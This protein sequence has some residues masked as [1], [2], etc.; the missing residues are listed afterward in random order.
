VELGHVAKKVTAGE[1]KRG[2]EALGQ[3]SEPASRCSEA[4]RHAE[5][6]DFAVIGLSEIEETFNERC[7]A[8]AVAPDVS[9]GFIRA[10]SS[11]SLR[12]L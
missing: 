6:P 3:K 5:N 1:V 9:T 11:T 10:G 2:V 8:R 12:T 4:V 7:L